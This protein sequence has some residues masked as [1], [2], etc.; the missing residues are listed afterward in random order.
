[1][2]AVSLTLFS[3][4]YLTS[5]SIYIPRGVLRIL[6]D[7]DNWMGAKIK[8]Q[9][10]TLCAVLYLQNCA[11]GICGHYHKSLDSFEYPPKFPTFKYL[12]I[13]QPQKSSCQ[14]FL[15]HKNPGIKNFEPPKILWSSPSFEI[16]S[17][18]HGYIYNSASC[19]KSN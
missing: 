4:R 16:W 13:K 8:T 14:I 3:P 17:A 6:S 19:R 7:G 2:D 11:A 10:M 15:P 12:K 5:K 1:M 9:H 18:L